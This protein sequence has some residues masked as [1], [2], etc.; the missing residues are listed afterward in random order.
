M[1]LQHQWISSDY[2]LKVQDKR[3]TSRVINLRK[4]DAEGKSLAFF[5]NNV[6]VSSAADDDDDV[7]W[8]F[9]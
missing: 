4:E 1:F 3:E 7:W 9:I 8:V 5:G 6:C 2:D